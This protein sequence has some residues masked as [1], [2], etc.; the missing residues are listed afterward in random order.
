MPRAPP[1]GRHSRR[2]PSQV[3]RAGVLLTGSP[4]L[5]QVKADATD[6]TQTLVFCRPG[7]VCGLAEVQAGVRGSVFLQARD[8]QGNNKTD[9][10][11]IFYYS[12]VGESGYST[13][14]QARALGSFAPG[15]YEMNFNSERATALT[16]IVTY[17]DVLVRFRAQNY[18]RGRAPGGGC[19]PTQL[20]GI[21]LRMNRL[22]LLDTV[23][24][25]SLLEINFLD[26]VPIPDEHTVHAATG[27]FV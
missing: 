2:L 8:S 3:S 7:V 21:R 27:R 18:A 20:C 10:L 4:H 14:A 19:D 23:L 16:L 24:T 22:E 13:S 15:T 1:A 6:P 9:I 11:D 5:L 17:S 26:E 25:R 12:V